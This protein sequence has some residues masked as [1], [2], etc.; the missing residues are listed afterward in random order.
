MTAGLGSPPGYYDE[1]WFPGLGAP[2]APPAPVVVAITA[3]VTGGNATVGVAVQITAT[4]GGVA[5]D[6]VSVDWDDGSTNTAATHIYGVAAA[7][8]VITATAPDT[9]SGSAPPFD[10]VDA[11]AEE[12]A[13]TPAKRSRKA[14]PE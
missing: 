2:P 12:D 14:Q 8:V 10:V 6:G 4:R 13:P 7:G 9:G 3:G 1:S 11:I 5:V